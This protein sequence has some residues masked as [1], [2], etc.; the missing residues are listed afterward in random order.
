MGKRSEFERKE[1]DFYPTP[2]R[3]TLPLIPHLPENVNFAEPCCGEMDLVHH[4]ESIGHRCNYCS[5][6]ERGH[7]ALDIKSFEAEVDYIITNPPW[8]RPILHEM[9]THFRNLKPTW[10]LL[11]A[12]W[13]HTKQS[14]EYIKY[15][16]KIV[17]IGR[18][19]WFPD[20]NSVGKDNCCWYLFDKEMPKF[21]TEFVGI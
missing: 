21:G 5:D 8:S 17:S 11:D 2:F 4:L 15:C 18:V 13:M 19:K 6:I 3:A 1:R 9:I 12:D 16:R 10:L 14:S 20:S 7:D